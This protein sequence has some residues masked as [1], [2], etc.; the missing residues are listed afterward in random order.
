MS[1][2]PVRYKTVDG[3]S[4]LTIDPG[5]EGNDLVRHA[6]LNRLREFC[7][8]PRARVLV[9]TGSAKTGFGTGGAV[10]RSTQPRFGAAGSMR[11]CEDLEIA[12]P[13]IAAVSGLAL[14]AGFLLA[15][16]CDLCI[17][18]SSARFGIK[19]SADYASAQL[20]PLPSMPRP[21]FAI[22][23][24]LRGDLIDAEQA[25]E[26]GLVNAVVPDGQLH[27]TVREIAHVVA[28]DDHASR[29]RRPIRTHR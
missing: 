29:S 18:A 4:W 7:R 13:T 21:G 25:C 16:M 17:A 12:K 20:A 28:S 23:A 3:V 26:L 1:E 10:T 19:D 15:Q 22:E 5:N 9:I 2:Q 6:V 24:L 8:D 11:F 27:R 14:G